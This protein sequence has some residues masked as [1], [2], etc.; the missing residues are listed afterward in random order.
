MENKMNTVITNEM[1][2]SYADKVSEILNV[3]AEKNPKTKKLSN[4]TWN[5][6]IETA[7]NFG[8]VLNTSYGYRLEVRI[9]RVAVDEAYAAGN[10]KNL[11]TLGFYCKD[12]YSKKYDNADEKGSEIDTIG[13]KAD[14]IFKIVED[15]LNAIANTSAEESGC[16]DLDKYANV[17]KSF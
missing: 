16:K 17:F 8:F 10:T 6:N 14:E 5:N 13:F 4:I 12:N 11:Y 2:K 9:S 1:I 3:W 7:S 15:R